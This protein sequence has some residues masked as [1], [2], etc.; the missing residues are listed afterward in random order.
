MVAGNV[1]GLL[2]CWDFI[3]SS[4]ELKLN[5]ITDVEDKN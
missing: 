5:R 4:P 2:L 1:Q 3:M